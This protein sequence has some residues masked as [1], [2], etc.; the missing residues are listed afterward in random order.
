MKYVVD[1]W[2]PSSKE[3]SWDRSLDEYPSYIIDKSVNVE[4]GE[5]VFDIVRTITTKKGEELHFIVPRTTIVQKSRD[6]VSKYAYSELHT[7]LKRIFFIAENP[8]EENLY[9]AYETHYAMRILRSIGYEWVPEEHTDGTRAEFISTIHGKI[10]NGEFN[11]YQF[12][13]DNLEEVEY[14]NY[15]T[16]EITPFDKKLPF[17]PKYDR[18]IPM[19][20]PNSESEYVEFVSSDIS[21]HM[22]KVV[23]YDES[24]YIKYKDYL[25]PDVDL[26][27]RL[28][29]KNSHPTYIFS[30][31]YKL[32][33]KNSEAYKK[34]IHEINFYDLYL[35]CTHSRNEIQISV[36][37]TQNPDRYN[38]MYV[39]KIFYPEIFQDVLDDHHMRFIVRPNVGKYLACDED[40]RIIDVY[41][42]GV[43]QTE[44]QNMI[45]VK[46]ENGAIGI[47]Q[48]I[49]LISELKGKC[50]NAVIT[51]KGDN[52]KNP[53]IVIKL[54]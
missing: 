43:I 22:H 12:Y 17:D 21:S 48:V 53:F 20:I 42:N 30:L 50:L 36:P 15:H 2:S 24:K 23:I 1:F 46:F 29:R 32:P 31:G 37:S 35:G 51:K 26:R 8:R 34:M 3:K 25:H 33:D 16:D 52:L 7:I 6:K 45:H 27:L 11:M 18:L 4:E 39:S 5:Y 13:L 47:F 10:L 9:D 38:F 19:F 41:D 40:Y 28:V 54:C 14:M 44:P 49:E